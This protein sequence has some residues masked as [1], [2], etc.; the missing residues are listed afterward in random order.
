MHAA[1]VA[2]LEDVVDPLEPLAAPEELVVDPPLEDVELAAPL[3][4][5]EPLVDPLAPDDA[6]SDP[7]AAQSATPMTPA[8]PRID[9]S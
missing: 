1:G 6:A 8:I 2:P 7:H 4:E 5:V 3:E 9:S